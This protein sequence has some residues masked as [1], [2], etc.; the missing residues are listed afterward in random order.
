MVRTISSFLKSKTDLVTGT[1][2]TTADLTAT[3]INAENTDVQNLIVDGVPYDAGGSGVEVGSFTPFYVDAT[4]TYTEQYGRYFVYGNFTCVNIY[5]RTTGVISGPGKAMAIGGIPFGIIGNPQTA[6]SRAAA[7]VYLNNN[8]T[9]NV[10]WPDVCG[11]VTTSTSK[12]NIYALVDN[13]G[14]NFIFYPSNSAN[15]DFA[16][17]FSYNNNL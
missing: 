2:L 5:I 14:A 7:S 4:A 1:S 9:W 10:A 6:L 17:S 8:S 12:I 16:M 15:R 13:D 11:S 3:T